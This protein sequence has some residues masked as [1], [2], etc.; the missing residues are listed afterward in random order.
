VRRRDGIAG[1]LL[2]VWCLLMAFAIV[3]LWNPPFLERWA[4][5]GRATEARDYKECGDELMRA[6]E[7]QPALWWYERALA[8]RPDYTGA[9]VNTAIAHGRLGRANLGIRLLEDALA[10][11]DVRHGVIAFNLAELLRARRE[12]ERAARLYA[13]ALA[14]DVEQDLVYTRLGETWIEAGRIERAREA[15][16]A[17]LEIQRDPTTPYRNML[18]AARNGLEAE[19]E[20]VAAI[21]SAL[22]RGVTHDD[23][24]PYDLALI[25]AE[26][27]SNPELAALHGRLGFIAARMGEADS[28]QAHLEQALAIDPDAPRAG[29]Y[30]ELLEQ[31]GP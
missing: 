13:E 11:E 23:L 20:H 29:H 30:R 6:G 7:Y 15:F 12:H 1:L 19:P 16:T 9:I 8:V 17:A 24:A 21:D 22:A 2:A 14:A 27:G 18:I 5:P 3:S 10:R 4:A 26:R 25:L 31:L 28:A